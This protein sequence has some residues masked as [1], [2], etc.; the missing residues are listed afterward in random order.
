MIGQACGAIFLPPCSE[1]F[2]RKYMYV[3]S[4]LLSA[5]ASVIAGAVPSLAAV[6]IGRFAT[7]VLS[8]VPNIVAIGSFE[9]IFEGDRRTWII[10]AW[11]TAAK[12]GLSVGVIFGTYVATG[13]GW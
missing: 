7:G 12:L 5:V 10:F 4:T 9:D 11:E 13:L 3:V 6:F 8:A 1:T 2:G